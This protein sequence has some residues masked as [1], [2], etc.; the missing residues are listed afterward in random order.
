[1]YY[2][3]THCHLHALTGAFADRPLE[4]AEWAAIDQFVADANAA[5]VRA[6]LNVATSLISTEHALYSARRYKNVFA[7]AGIHPCDGQSFEGDWRKLL[8]GI[9]RV[10][11][12]SRSEIYALGE[13]GIDFYHQPYDFEIQETLFRGHIER[14]L[15][16]DL[17][18]VIHIRDA[19][20]AALE[21]IGDY[22][23]RI[24]GV[25]HCFSLD[26]AAAE[27]LFSWGLSIGVDGPI[28]YPRNHALREIV[29]R[30]PLEFLLLETDAPF[31]T[32]QE[33]R[34]KPNRPAYLPLI[35]ATIGKLRALSGEEIGEIT[36]AN[37]ARLFKLPVSE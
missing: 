18:L 33:Y 17:P 4:Q 21:I 34:G 5:G 13:T 26:Q 25:V 6:I 24:R 22:A 37:A 15:A 7:T 8:S 9:D 35:A 31:L 11:A 14:A 3:D 28:G 12:D 19:G 36:S 2:T 10:L 27:K 32:P 16:A 1:M 29:A 20:D 23:G 30:M